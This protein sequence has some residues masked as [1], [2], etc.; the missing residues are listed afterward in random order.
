[1][2]LSIPDF[3]T[4]EQIEPP[5]FK[6]LYAYFLYVDCDA[7]QTHHEWSEHY[8]KK[9]QQASKAHSPVEIMILINN[10][11]ANQN[12]NK[13]DG[14]ICEFG[15]Y[16]GI[17]SAKLSLIAAL[18]NLEFFVFDSFEGL[19]DIE[20]YGSE[21]QHAVYNSGEYCATIETVSNNIK[22]YGSI[23]NTHLIKG[24]FSD[25]L[26][27]HNDV[28]KISYAFIDVDLC[29]S[30]EECLEYV[31]PRLQRGSILFSHEAQDPDYLPI[32]EKYG[33]LNSENFKSFGVGTGINNTQICMF[34]KT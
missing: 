4:F 31:L 29:K 23:R 9:K 5:I 18:F 24:W 16:T 30:L 3:K 1:M 15:C 17:S 32:F 8:V 28:D 19:P 21:S 7:E 14:K 10:I 25:T 2:I 6:I 26:K 33:L 12:Q 13:L 11:I 27:K 34:M 22:K 20:K